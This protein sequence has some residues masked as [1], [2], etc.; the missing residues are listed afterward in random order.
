MTSPFMIATL[1]FQVMILL[2]AGLALGV[3]WKQA[4]VHLPWLVPLVV[5]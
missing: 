1:L 2:F 5:S 4:R 3:A